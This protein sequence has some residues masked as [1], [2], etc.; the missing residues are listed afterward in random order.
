MPVYALFSYVFFL[1]N[2]SL[3]GTASFVAEILVVVGVFISDAMVS[4]FLFLSGAIGLIYSLWLANRVLG[5]PLSGYLMIYSDLTKNEL[6]YLG[7]LVIMTI[8]LGFY[9]NLI[10]NFFHISLGN[11]F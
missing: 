7:L 6:I 3:P 1:A 10:L 8:G 2:F 9:P 11:I 5:G 4:A